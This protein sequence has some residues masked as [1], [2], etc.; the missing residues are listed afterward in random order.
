MSGLRIA[1]I[2]SSRHPIAEPFAGG[3]ESHVWHLSR[4]LDAR[5]HDVTL[6]AAPGS[7]PTSTGGAVAMEALDLSVAAAADSSMRPR[8]WVDEHHA[9]L[10]LMLRLV[11]TGADEFDLVHNHSLHYLPIAMAPALRTPMISTLHTPPTPWLESAMQS[12]RTDEAGTFVAVSRHTARAWRH[13]CDGAEVIPNGI[14]TTAWTPGPGG[15]D[16]VWF[17]RITPEKGLH[18]AIEVARLAGRRLLIAGPVCDQAYFDDSIVKHLGDDVRYLGHLRQGDLD[19]V[20]GRAAACLVTPLWDEPYGL[21][22]AESLACG[23]PVIAFARGGIPEVLD[24]DCGLLVE[25]G[26]VTAMARGVGEVAQLSRRAARRRAVEHCSIQTMVDRYVDL[27]G[28]LVT[29]VAA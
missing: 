26:D 15:D 9:Y 19:S 27:F 20:V 10:S 7:D 8:Q 28:R 25:P 12:V 17:G 23:T 22:V 3:L 1:V 16:L 18:L 29:R 2:G 6:F 24:A 21:V 11:A 13:R 4:E 5:G 14:D